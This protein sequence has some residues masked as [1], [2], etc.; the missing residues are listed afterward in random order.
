LDGSRRST[1]LLLQKE[2]IEARRPVWAGDLEFLSHGLI[3]VICLSCLVPF[4]LAIQLVAC[5]V[6]LKLVFLRQCEVSK[7]DRY[8]I[9]DGVMPLARTA[10]VP[11]RHS[12]GGLMAQRA[13]DDPRHWLRFGSGPGHRK[14]A[15]KNIG[16]DKV[17]VAIHHVPR[18]ASPDRNRMRHSLKDGNPVLLVGGRG[19]RTWT[20]G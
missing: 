6:M 14:P 9:R 11:R 13:T 5:M 1:E 12:R 18:I 3:E 16:V 7:Q 17:Q 2:A 20:N 15:C 19:G 10:V 8:P 4:K